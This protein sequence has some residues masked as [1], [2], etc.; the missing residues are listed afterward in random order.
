MTDLADEMSDIYDAEPAEEVSPQASPTEAWHA[1]CPGQTQTLCDL[2]ITMLRSIIMAQ[3]Y[4]IADL[5]RRVNGKP[6]TWTWIDGV[7][8]EERG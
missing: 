2:Y 8:T 4:H 7:Y 5:E 3:G 1:P 6:L